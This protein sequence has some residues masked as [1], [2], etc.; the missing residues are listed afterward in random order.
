MKRCCNCRTDI[1]VFE[2]CLAPS[3]YED[4]CEECHEGHIIESKFASASKEAEELSADAKIKYLR[5]ESN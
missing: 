4:M 1:G 3:V 2:V 5:D